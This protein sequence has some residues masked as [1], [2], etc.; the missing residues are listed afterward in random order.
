MIERKDNFYT[1]I[2]LFQ[3]SILLTQKSE[4][5]ALVH[6]WR[7]AQKLNIH[8]ARGNL[9]DNDR[10]AWL[11]NPIQSLSEYEGIASSKIPK[12][13]QEAVG[14]RRIGQNLPMESCG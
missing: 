2:L 7:T 5:P 8:P 9:R 11:L 12:N 14:I 13:A 3:L 6:S 1:P 4:S 10:S